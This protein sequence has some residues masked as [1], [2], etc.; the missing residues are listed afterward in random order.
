MGKKI[1]FLSFLLFPF[2]ALGQNTYKTGNVF[3]NENR[4]IAIQGV[5]VRNLNSK[6]LVF[7][8]KDGH[9]AISAKTGDLISYGMVGYEVDTV[10]LVN[11]FPKNVYLR[12][13]INNLKPVNIINTKVSP[14]LNT[15]DPNAMPA[16]QVDYGKNKGGI[17]LGLGYGKFRKQLAK[18]Q[19]LEEEDDL[20]EE[21]AKNFNI[22]VIQ[23]LVKYKGNDLT[24]Y[25]DLYRPSLSRIKAER[26]FNYTYYIASTFQEWK[27]LPAEAKKLTPLIKVKNN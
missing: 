7:T 5:S 8:D 6:A 16:R 11:L 20:Q 4:S 25:M 1:Y 26:P 12:A 23:K 24:D 3:D 2:F 21:I 19:E 14:F 27:E 17:R 22:D 13:A 9:F 18:V 10:Y 15:K